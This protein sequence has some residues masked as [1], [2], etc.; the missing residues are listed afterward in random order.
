MDCVIRKPIVCYGYSMADLGIEVVVSEILSKLLVKAIGCFKCVCKQW[1]DELSS[2]QLAALHSSRIGSSKCRKQITI[3]PLSIFMDSIVDGQVDIGARKT[4]CFPGKT[5]PLL[6][7]I[8]STV[9]G[10]LLVCNER[11]SYQ[12][13]LWN[14]TTMSFKILFDEDSDRDAADMYF[15]TSSDLK[16]LQ[17]KRR[18]NYDLARIYSR[19]LGTWRNVD[20]FIGKKYAAGCYIWSVGFFV[21]NTLYFTVKQVRV[22]GDIH[23]IGFDVITESFKRFPF[24]L[25]NDL[26]VYD[27]H[28][29]TV[30]NKL[31][32]FV[33]EIWP[34]VNV[35]LFKYQD[36]LWSKVSSFPNVETF[37][38]VEWCGAS[39]VANGKLILL[40]KFGN[41]AEVYMSVQDFEY[42]QHVDSF[43]W[44]KGALFGRKGALF[45]ETVDSA[46]GFIFLLLLG[47][48]LGLHCSINCCWLFLL[49]LNM[50]Y[51]SFV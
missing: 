32:M 51:L 15:D 4:I 24:P 9:G 23:I 34:N 2:C 7:H 36:N 1:R 45:L 3:Q 31:H 49:V 13:M 16:I 50:Y 46:I 18:R 26:Y 41:I 5:R 20:F 40:P 25:V 10:L 48:F 43:C 28:F 42:L 47:T 8:I 14:P 35:S 22:R 17:I 29:L 6:L 30:N 33:V 38:F 11:P 39:D 27:G 19:R 21:N 12:M 44:L 37:S